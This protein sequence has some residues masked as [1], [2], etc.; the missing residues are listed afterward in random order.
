MSDDEQR[1]IIN[2]N[3]EDGFN[4]IDQPNDGENNQIIEI[5]NDQEFVDDDGLN[6]PN[7]EDNED[8]NEDDD[9]EDDD[10]GGDL[11]DEDDDEGW[12][13]EEWLIA[14]YPNVIIDGFDYGLR[15][16]LTEINVPEGV[17]DIPNDAMML[18][19]A[20]SSVILP[21]TLVSIGAGA[22][23]YCTSLQTIII[24]DNVTHIG[25]VAFWRCTNL[26]T[27]Q[28]PNDNKNYMVGNLKLRR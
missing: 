25:E 8:D 17:T 20:C 11:P 2:N 23:K 5:E 19:R 22:F 26:S 24:P 9:N 13:A 15:V 7:D 27:I 10:D 28:L 18:C 6:G 16:E 4:Q 14:E 3:N 21:S 1:D 12:N